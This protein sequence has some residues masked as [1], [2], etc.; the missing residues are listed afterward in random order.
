MFDFQAAFAAL[1]AGM[2]DITQDQIEV[3][4]PRVNVTARI[5]GQ[6]IYGTTTVDDQI[7]STWEEWLDGEEDPAADLARA[8]SGKRQEAAA[9]LVVGDGFEVGVDSEGWY[10]YPVTRPA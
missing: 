9:K 2:I 10:A 6:M 7:I 1:K 3:Q 5:D 4:L 8:I